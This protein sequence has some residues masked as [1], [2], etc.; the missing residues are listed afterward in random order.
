MD[1][2]NVRIAWASLAADVAASGA[3][4]DMLLE[5][6]IAAM[7][8]ATNATPDRFVDE[9][10]PTSARGDGEKRIRL[11]D[12]PLVGFGLGGLGGFGLPL[13]LPGSSLLLFLGTGGRI[14]GAFLAADV[15]AAGTNLVGAKR[16]L[17]AMAGAADTHANWLLDALDVQFL[18][19]HPFMGLQGEAIFGKERAGAL[20]LHVGPVNGDRAVRRRG[21]KRL[22]WLGVGFLWTT[23]S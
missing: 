16:G 9:I 11:L 4:L 10:L 23:A 3:F 7:A 22:G 20:L 17:A 21:G 8:G 13:L 19:R 14:T 18:R 12:F 1:R 6:G 15:L 2:G 5:H